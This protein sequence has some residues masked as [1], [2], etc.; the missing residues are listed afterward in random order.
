LEAIHVINY[1]NYD[2]VLQM[3]Y[4]KQREYTS[5]R[6]S[7][8]SNV[9]QHLHEPEMARSLLQTFWDQYKNDNTTYSY[10][11]DVSRQLLAFDVLAESAHKALI[12]NRLSAQAHYEFMISFPNRQ[13]W[14]ILSSYLHSM[15]EG[16]LSY[17]TSDIDH[18]LHITDLYLQAKADETHFWHDY[19]RLGNFLVFARRFE[20]AERAYR[21]A[22]E[23]QND[24]AV[25]YRNLSFVL[26]L[27][28]RLRE[29][30][31]AMGQ[32]YFIERNF[33]LA[34]KEYVDAMS[35]GEN[36]SHIYEQLARSYSH[37]GRFFETISVCA[38]AT[39]KKQTTKLYTLWIDALRAL[40]RIDQAL[41]VA[42]RAYASFPDEHY[43]KFQARLVLP[44]IYK[45]ENDIFVHRARFQRTLHAWWIK[46]R[47]DVSYVSKNAINDIK[48]TNFYLPYQ[49]Q[50]DLDM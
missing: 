25:G 9:Y 7:A 18:A 30:H 14:E 2:R 22:I 6:D 48:T 15:N 23:R 16:D 8:L 26:G 20:K 41:E 5:K 31:L 43:F 21:Q 10:V 4:S 24:C 45:S 47:N 40:N 19:I 28:G 49:G 35:F 29:S 13:E 42:E 27:L 33:K 36:L 12:L 38:E 34:I 1:Y 11:T 44:V 50:C 46:C 32:S 37:E 39:V 17:I 3:L